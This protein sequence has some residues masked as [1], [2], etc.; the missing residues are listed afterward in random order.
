LQ[1]LDFY[2]ATVTG[3]VTAEPTSALTVVQAA[4]LKLNTPE[5]YERAAAHIQRAHDDSNLH[6]LGRSGC[7]FALLAARQG[8]PVVGYETLAYVRGGNLKVNLQVFLLAQVS[9]IP[10]GTTTNASSVSQL[11]INMEW[12]PYVRSAFISYN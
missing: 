3:R 8:R 5:S 12:K 2:Q 4:C 6:F 7:I 9:R 1:L 11:K 10:C